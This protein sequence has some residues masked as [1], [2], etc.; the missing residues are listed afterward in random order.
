[1]KINPINNNQNSFRGYKNLKIVGEK[2]VEVPNGEKAI[3]VFVAGGKEINKKVAEANKKVL[4][5]YFTDRITIAG[6]KEIDKKVAEANKEIL[7]ANK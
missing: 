4:E 1:M 6:G 2:F 3:K 7:E 5:K